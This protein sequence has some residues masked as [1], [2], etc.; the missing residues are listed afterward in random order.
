[1]RNRPVVYKNE[2]GDRP[3]NYDL[4]VG[5][6][7]ACECVGACVWETDLTDYKSNNL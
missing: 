4:L 2:T 6:T 5:V 7:R 1:M 3:I